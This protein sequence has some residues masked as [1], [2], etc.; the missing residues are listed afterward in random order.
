MRPIK[1]E[2]KL[3]GGPYPHQAWWRIKASN[4]RIYVA[5]ETMGRQNAR[6]V[7]NNIINAVK[8]G[9]Y[10]VVETHP[11]SGRIMERSKK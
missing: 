9:N 7:I 5:S 3:T 8:K 2:I 10:T 1:F 11:A 6:R 4:A